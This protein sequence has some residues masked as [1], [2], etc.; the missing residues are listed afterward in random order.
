MDIV[1][2]SLAGTSG[3]E[4]IENREEKEAVVKQFVANHPS[5]NTV[6][7]AVNLSSRDISEDYNVKNG[8]RTAVEQSD[9]VPAG[10]QV[11]TQILLLEL[12]KEQ[13]YILRR[14]M[15]AE[16]S[17]YN[18]CVMSAR[19]AFGSSDVGAF[20]HVDPRI[21]T[22]ALAWTQIQNLRIP[23]DYLLCQYCPDYDGMDVQLQELEEPLEKRRDGLNQQ[24]LANWILVRNEQARE[25]DG[26][27]GV[28]SNSLYM[29]I[30][31][32]FTARKAA[33]TNL[34]RG[35]IETFY[36]NTRNRHRNTSRVL[37]V[38]QGSISFPEMKSESTVNDVTL[39]PTKVTQFV[40][41]HN[42]PD[43]MNLKDVNL[44]TKVHMC[45]FTGDRSVAHQLVDSHNK[46]VV[47]WNPPGNCLIVDRL[48]GNRSWMELHVPVVYKTKE[49]AAHDASSLARS[50]AL[51]PGQITFQTVWNAIYGVEKFGD[52]F[53]TEVLEP[54]QKQYSVLQ[55]KLSEIVSQLETEKQRLGF[56]QANGRQRKGRMFQK[57][58]DL[59]T[60]KFRT[61]RAMRRLRRK[62]EAKVDDLHYKTIHQLFSKYDTVFIPPFDGMKNARKVGEDGR[63]RKISKQT[64]RRMISLRHAKF[65]ERLLF[66][67]ERLGKTVIVCSEYCS[68]RTC[69]KCGYQQLGIRGRDW[70]CSKCN[71]Y[72]DRDGGAA[73]TIWVMNVSHCF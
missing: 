16:Q 34:Q 28:P 65:R 54:L 8:V 11:A 49:I 36:F 40:E 35:N 70:T 56:N 37:H 47:G 67:A 64:A 53:S 29:A 46:N 27:L 45:G 63:T 23:D 61:K 41:S 39:F 2:D 19:I 6:E 43:Y 3:D 14:W 21:D 50:C 4:E 1:L 62:M 69:S 9:S 52:G 7:G 13:R 17:Y 48:H 12:T 57:I 26:T 58:R 73:R 32:F 59:N 72:H 38:A 60:K 68:T 25:A 22:L 24:N 71:E 33:F 10:T 5:P 18:M 55:E 31:D 51:D 42:A 15:V 66:V 20:K 30:K 44:K